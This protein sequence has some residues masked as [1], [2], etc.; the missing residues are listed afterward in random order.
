MKYLI[1]GIIAE[2][3]RLYPV[4]ICHLLVMPNHIH[5][6][7]VVQSPEAIP[8]FLQYV[9]RESAHAI[10]RLLNRR[11]HTVWCTGSDTPVILDPATVLRRL[12]YIYLNPA[13]AGLV[14]S[15]DQY[16]N[17]SSWQAL[18]SGAT[19]ETVCRIPRDYIVDFYRVASGQSIEKAL[20]YLRKK[21][22]VLSPATFRL[23]PFSW[24]PHF[25]DT[26]K[27]DV[28]NLRHQVV[29]DV[30][31]EEAQL[32]RSRTEPVLG[33][34]RL[35]SQPMDKPYLPSKSGRRSIC[36]GASQAVRAL[37]LDWYFAL[38]ETARAALQQLRQ[39][40]FVVLPPGFFYPGGYLLSNVLPSASPLPL[41]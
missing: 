40:R 15:I 21:D 1:K 37:F 12:S 3:A 27:Q 5:I 41:A 39:G 14:E 30:R 25:I 26:Q 29:M 8:Q 2:A 13:R 7:L 20:E 18:L 9:K 24:T 28:E 33:A 38:R 36:L 17:I 10:N 4:T 32:C 34:S 31:Q 23:E 6:I 19:E 35:R 16:P 22:V 11:R